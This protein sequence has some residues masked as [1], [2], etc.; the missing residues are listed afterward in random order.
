MFIDV[1]RLGVDWTAICEGKKTSLP[2]KYNQPL[3]SL[4]MYDLCAVSLISVVLVCLATWRL[5]VGN[6][7]FH[8]NPVV[9][10]TV[11]RPVIMVCLKEASG[12]TSG[13]I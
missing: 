6:T 11:L 7:W 3:K 13:V 2:K 9:L 10:L 8:A 5:Q 1:M 4:A 12:E